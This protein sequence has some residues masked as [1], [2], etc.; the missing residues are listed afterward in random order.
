MN[1]VWSFGFV[2]G[3][4]YVVRKD[5]CDFYNQPFAQGEKLT[6]VERHFLP[7]HGGHTIVIEQRKLYLQEG[8]N[9]DILRS[10]D[11]YLSRSD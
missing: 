1:D 9:G 2:G 4:T 7:Y 11:A 8:M 6:F 3:A 5:F 10:L